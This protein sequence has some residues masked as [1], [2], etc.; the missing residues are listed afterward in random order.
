MEPVCARLIPP[1]DAEGDIVEGSEK[2]GM[3]TMGDRDAV[4]V[5]AVRTPIGKRGRGL[6][7]IR[8]DDLAAMVMKAA[9]S[10]AGVDPST[11]EDIILGCATPIGEQGWNV[12]RLAALSAGFPVEVPAVTVNR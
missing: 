7:G 6:A 8:P 11:V 1:P 5:S 3:S 9:V 12:G 4:I 10:R 2:N